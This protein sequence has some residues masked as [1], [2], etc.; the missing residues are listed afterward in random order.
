[1]KRDNYTFLVDKLRV[2]TNKFDDSIN[3]RGTFLYR[4]HAGYHMHEGHQKR[5][6]QSDCLECHL[7]CELPLHEAY[8]GLHSS[9][10]D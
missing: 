5:V 8:R 2:A 4:Q 7:L 3:L 6:P 9:F 10:G 1:M